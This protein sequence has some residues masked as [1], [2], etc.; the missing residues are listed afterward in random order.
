MNSSEP[1]T[2]CSHWLMACRP[3]YQLLQRKLIRN[4]LLI[5]SHTPTGAIRRPRREILRRPRPKLC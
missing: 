3:A 5:F 4:N 2:L 1:P